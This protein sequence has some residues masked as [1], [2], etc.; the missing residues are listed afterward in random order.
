MK[1]GIL[2]LPLHTNYGGIL[3]AYALQTVLERMGHEVKVINRKHTRLCVSMWKL[4]F[5]IIRRF[6]SNVFSN[7]Q[8]P[9]FLE[10]KMNKEWSIVTQHTQSF[11]SKYINLLE[12][13]DYRDLNEDDF[14]AIVVGSDQVWRPKYFGKKRIKEAYLDFA[15]SWNIKRIAYAA[16]FGTDSNEY[17]ELQRWEC[18]SLLQ[19]FDFVSVRELAG[20]DLCAKLFNIKAKQLVDPT[21]LLNKDDYLNLI[22]KDNSNN[23]SNGLLVYALDYNNELDELI[24]NISIAKHLKPFS[25]NSK[26]EDLNAPCSERIQPPVEQWL[27][28]FDNAE[29]VVTDSFH[30]CVFSIIF[31]KSFLVIGNRKR[32]LSRF[33]TLLNLFG[34]TDRLV[35]SGIDKSILSKDIN[36]DEVDAKVESAKYQALQ[37]LTINLI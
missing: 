4:P 25:V 36:W 16:S 19:L 33:Y 24:E 3:Q 11:I 29:F 32:G 37:I 1:I 10:K 15:K 35:T 17:S 6:L 2:T 5:V 34:L 20:V 23:V 22:N 14:E 31:H 9:V 8:T 13:T 12:T 30:A 21:L 7:S 27:K 26:F 28:G 18:G